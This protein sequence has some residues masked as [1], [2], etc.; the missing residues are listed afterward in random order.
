MSTERRGLGDHEEVGMKAGPAGMAEGI[1]ELR[2]G[3]HGV[4]ILCEHGVAILGE[5]GDWLSTESLETWVST[6]S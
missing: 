5:Y 1:N 2:W 4:P 3:E 6:E